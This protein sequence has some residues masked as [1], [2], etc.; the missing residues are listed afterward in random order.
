MNAQC[1]LIREAVKYLNN[2][3]CFFNACFVFIIPWSCV[4][5]QTIWMSLDR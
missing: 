2:L 1:T 4:H 3:V 5:G